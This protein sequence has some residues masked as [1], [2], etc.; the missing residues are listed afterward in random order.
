MILK[1]IVLPPRD[2]SVYPAGH[3]SDYFFGNWRWIFRG[4]GE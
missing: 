4:G 1:G 2:V 3:F